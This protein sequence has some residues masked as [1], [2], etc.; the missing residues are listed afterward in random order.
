MAKEWYSDARKLANAEAFS[1]TKMEKTLG[2]IK[3]E[4]YELTEKLKEAQSGH[5]S[6]EAGL[7]NAEKQ[8][9]DQHQK[10]HV[11][12]I[13]LATKKQAILDLK[14]ALQK[15][16]EE[17]QLAKEAAEVEKRAAYQLGVEET[18]ARLTE[19]LSEVCKDY[20]SIS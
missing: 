18:E 19:E 1:R 3:Q 14:T 10:L 2:A 17:V 7:K 16:K 8:V 4:Q 6:V 11:T 13:N 12:E 5:L 9:E 15:A 20:C